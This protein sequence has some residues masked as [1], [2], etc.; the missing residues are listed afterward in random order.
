MLNNEYGNPL[1]LLVE[2]DED[3]FEF[4]KRS[5]GKSLDEYHLEQVATLRQA[6]EFI[7]RR[8]PDLVLTDYKLPD[9]CGSELIQLADGSAD[10]SW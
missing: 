10:I 1:I 3:H 8:T 4:V 6:R 9:G 7:D 2:D 5:L